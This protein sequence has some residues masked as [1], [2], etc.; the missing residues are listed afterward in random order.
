MHSILLDS[1]SKINNLYGIII[2]FGYCF[3]TKA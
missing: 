3:T 1:Y 2:V